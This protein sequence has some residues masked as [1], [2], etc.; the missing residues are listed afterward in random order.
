MGLFGNKQLSTSV[1]NI[2]GFSG[3]GFKQVV[4]LTIDEENQKLLL[5]GPQNKEPYTISLKKIKQVIMGNI[6][7][8]VRNLKGMTLEI[9]YESQS[10]NLVLMRFLYSP[11]ISAHY[12]KFVKRLQ[13]I[14]EG[15]DSMEL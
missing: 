7:D 10:G 14:I 2:D 4:K 13:S 12:V 8:K 3:A 15:P 9:E 5:K 11:A 1:F 6:V